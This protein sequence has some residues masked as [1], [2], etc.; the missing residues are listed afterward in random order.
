LDK[1]IN[2]YLK[3]WKV[4][5]Q[6]SWQP[7]VT[8]RQILSHSAGFTVHG[9]G[10]YSSGGKIPSLTDVLKGHP[11]ANSAPVEVNILPGLQTRYSG[12]G[13]T[14]AQMLVVDRFGKDFAQLMR[15]TVFEPLQMKDSSYEQPLPTPARFSPQPD[16]CGMAWLCPAGATCTPSSPPR[17]SGAPQQTLPA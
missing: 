9:F 4:P 12:G 3:S 14:V 1:D 10:G 8:L 13:M 11:P 5:S 17:V 6:G 7:R 2:G 15:E 16:T